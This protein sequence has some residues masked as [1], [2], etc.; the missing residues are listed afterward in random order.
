[1]KELADILSAARE[2]S[3]AGEPMAVATIIGVRGSTYRRE[4]ARLLV[5][6]SGRLTGNISGGCL[7]GD[8]AVVAADVMERRLPRVTLY[9]LTADDDAVWGLGL[10]C[11]GAIEVFVEPVTGDDL[12]WQAAEAVLDGA[13]LGLVT[14]VE[15]GATVPAGGRMVVWPDGRRQGS[16]GDA[17]VDEEAA[18]IV[19][20]ASGALR[21][22]VHTLGAEG[23][24]QIRLFVEVLHPPL[25]LIVCGAGHDAIPVVRLASQL[26]WRVLVVDRREAFLTPERFPGATGFVRTEF[27]EAGATVPTDPNSFVLVMTHNYVHD[28]DLLRAFLPTPVRY[29]GMLGPRARTEKML[30][31]LV[32]EGVAI[33]EDRRAQIYGPVGLDIG[34]DTP[35]EIALAAL[36]EILAVAHGRAGGFLRARSGPIHVP[37]QDAGPFVSAVILA[38]GASTRMGRP[39]L[40]IPVRG[41][42]MIRRIVAAALASRCSEAIVVLGTHADL[43]RSLLDGLAVRIVE[44]RDPTEG[45]ASSIRA[46]IEAVSPDASG[47]VILLADQPFVSAEVIDRLIEAV[48]S[49]RRRIVASEHH[50]AA[51]P[52]VYFPRAYFPELLALEGDRGAR[53]VIQA[54]P[55]ECVLVPLPE[56]CAADIDTSED[57]SAIGD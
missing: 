45:M 14:V 1:M 39:K 25:R 57:L 17:A 42:P 33:S 27:P 5:T 26:G 29:L 11:N 8:V 30:G 22:R 3:A 46:G 18:R 41:T 54:H 56:S 28:R 12:L 20:C 19:L 13:T 48:A 2:A 37:A 21:S 9:D 43:Y 23:G 4:G 7:E 31:E 38:A 51:T 55:R 53:S 15:G 36:S 16:L 34:G 50:G 47:A 6:R 35:D 52:P 44:N 49:D 40:A 24:P 32:A 10:G